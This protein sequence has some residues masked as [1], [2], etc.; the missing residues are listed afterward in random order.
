MIFYGIA[1]KPHSASGNGYSFLF[2]MDESRSN[3]D[4]PYHISPFPL[5][6]SPSFAESRCSGNTLVA[7]RD[8]VLKNLYFDFFI[9]DFKYPISQMPP[10][11]S[12]SS[13]RFIKAFLR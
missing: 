4:L 12:Y 1:I 9:I 5:H 7:N 10:N 13:L 6:L 8:S 11:I 3:P 2:R